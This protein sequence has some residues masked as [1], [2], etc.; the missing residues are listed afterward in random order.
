MDF[1][2]I[3]T[4]RL[5]ILPTKLAKDEG[6]GYLLDLVTIYSDPKVIEY[7]FNPG[8]KV[9]DDYV[10]GLINGE[11]TNWEKNNHGLLLAIDHHIDKAV[12]F[13]RFQASPLQ[14]PRDWEVACGVHPSHRRDKYA[15]EAVRAAVSNEFTRGHERVVAV[16]DRKNVPSRRLIESL[17]FLRG[18]DRVLKCGDAPEIREYVYEATAEILKQ[19]ASSAVS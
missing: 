1:K 12:A 15:R 6:H 13:V 9:T 16:L 8:I 5:T 7:L 19:S 17:G 4:E 18:E 10:R 11:N 2:P 3:E 14:P